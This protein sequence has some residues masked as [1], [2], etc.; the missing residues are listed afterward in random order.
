[1]E[2]NE[3]IVQ[4]EL[5]PVPFP[6]LLLQERDLIAVTPELYL[7]NRLQCSTIPGNC[8]QVKRHHK[9]ALRRRP[10]E[11]CLGVCLT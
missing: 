6:L 2:R 4:E 5:I 8:Q 9:R 1:M 11:Q 3:M 7:L 10:R